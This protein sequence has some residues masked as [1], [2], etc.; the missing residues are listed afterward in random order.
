MRAFDYLDIAIPSYAEQV[1]TWKRLRKQRYETKPLALPAPKPETHYIVT[2]PVEPVE[3]DPYL[4]AIEARLEIAT[5]TEKAALNN[6]TS[7]PVFI[8]KIV[9]EFFNKPIKN[10]Y[11]KSR[12]NDISIY[13]HIA[14]AAVFKF[15]KLSKKRIARCF[16]KSDH[17]TIM[18]ALKKIE[19]LQLCDQVFNYYLGCLDVE[20]ETKLKERNTNQKYIGKHEQ[21]RQVHAKTENKFKWPKEAVQTAIELCS[22]GTSLKEIALIISGQFNQSISHAAVSSMLRHRMGSVT[23]CRKLLKIDSEAKEEIVQTGI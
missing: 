6:L 10:F 18:Y 19:K 7:L 2:K 20:I 9:A 3:C 11:D 12:K 16:G 13:R 4:T 21:K 22:S 8:T 15:T 23:G 1:E 5:D 14:M 17:T